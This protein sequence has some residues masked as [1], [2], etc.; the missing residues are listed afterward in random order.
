MKLSPELLRSVALGIGL[1]LSV[2]SC[3]VLESEKLAT[4]DDDCTKDK[5]VVD[6]EK[7][8]KETGTDWDYCPPC[9]RG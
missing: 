5:C 8:A 9:G 6:C 1:G 2:T 4:H 3:G 7:A